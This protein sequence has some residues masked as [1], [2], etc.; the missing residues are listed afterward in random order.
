M[1]GD[2]YELAGD[3][4]EHS[5]EE[6]H[7]GTGHTPHREADG[8]GEGPRFPSVLQDQAPAPRDEEDPNAS[9]NTAMLQAE[10]CAVNALLQDID[11]M[12]RAR[13][14]V[15]SYARNSLT[16]RPLTCLPNSWTR[17]SGVRG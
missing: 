17:R 13:C 6:D 10:E 3:E 16:W 1:S 14:A 8:E 4:E 11:A 9:P 7:P 12:A 2:E 15:A 5:Q